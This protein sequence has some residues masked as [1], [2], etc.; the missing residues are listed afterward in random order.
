VSGLRFE[1]GTSRILSRGV[2]HSTE[3]ESVCL[4]LSVFSCDGRGLKTNCVPSKE[5]YRLSIWFVS[6]V[7]YLTKQ[8]HRL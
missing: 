3:F 5:S 2:N 7:A 6:F 1:P 8:L 4:R